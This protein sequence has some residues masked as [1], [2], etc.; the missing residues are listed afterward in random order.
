MLPTVANT[1]AP[2][3]VVRY[4]SE[5]PRNSPRLVALWNHG[6][7]IA[8]RVFVEA[9]PSLRPELAEPGL[10]A[11]EAELRDYLRSGADDTTIAALTKA[12][13]NVIIWMNERTG[14]FAA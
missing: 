12:R 4:E 1:F 13:D 10:E 7:E 6:A 9:C 8:N 3:T 2:V 11:I 5:H 14:R